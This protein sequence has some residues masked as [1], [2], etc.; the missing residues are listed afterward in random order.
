MK[1]IWWLTRG[2]LVWVVVVVAGGGGVVA[3]VGGLGGGGGGGGGDG[4]CG[5]TG[6][7]RAHRAEG[8][9]RLSWSS[10]GFT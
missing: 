1:Y 3:G 2:E 5:D 7:L 10:F 9:T 4:G 8:K 6:I